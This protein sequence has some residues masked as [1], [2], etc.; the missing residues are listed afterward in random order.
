[1][2]K[3]K[4]ILY[5]CLFLG[6]P[7]FSLGQTA[8]LEQ[9]L[10]K[11]QKQAADQPFEK[12]YLHTDKPYYASGDTI[13]FKGYILAG[14]QH[15][16]S[17][18]SN[19]LHVDLIN[20]NNTIIKGLKLPLTLGFTSG[21]IALPDT[22]T[23]GS[24]RL[25][26]Y[27]TWMRNN[28]NDYFFDKTF[29]IV[30]ART[31][32]VFTKTTYNYSVEQGKQNV[33]VTIVY[34]NIDQKPYA[35]REVKYEVD[36]AGQRVASGKG[37]T[38]GKGEMKFA[39]NNPDAATVN[40]GMLTT[41]I[42]L[43]QS[44]KVEKKIPIKAAS[45]DVDV[46]FF[47]EGGNL[48]AGLQSK[49]AFK[50][51]GADGLGID[52]GGTLL[53]NNNVEVTKFASTHLG[54]GTFLF[55]PKAGTTYKAK[56]IIAGSE[57]TY[58]LPKILDRGYVMEINNSNPQNL[59]IQV[60]G[61]E[62]TTN[63]LSLIAQ[64]G[65]D[66][67][68]EARNKPGAS[69]ITAIIPKDKLPTGVVQFTL[70]TQAGEP[71]IER[72]VFI[73]N[74]DQLK[75]TIGTDKAAYGIREKV[76]LKLNAK[77]KA[78]QPVKGNFS[79]AVINQS[80]APVNESAET[81]ILSSVLLTSDLKGY[82]EQPN[83]YFTNADAKKAQE[84]DVLMLTQGYHRFAWR[85]FLAPS[86]SNEITY[87]PERDIAISGIVK[88]HGKPIP[89]ARV[90]ITNFQ[91]GAFV[92]DTLTDKNGRFVFEIG[93]ADS[94]LFTIR[95]V[96]KGDDNLIIQMDTPPLVRS[97]NRNESDVA[98]NLSDG[99]ENFLQNSKKQF[100][101]DPFSSGH[102]V[103]L[104]QIEVKDTRTARQ[105]EVDKAVKY[106]NNYNGKGVANQVITGEEIGKLGGSTIFTRLNGIIAGVYVKPDGNG[107]DGFYST[108]VASKIEER[109]ELDD[110]GNLTTTQVPAPPMQVVIDGFFGR[111]IS[112]V[113]IESISS[114]EVLRSGQLL[115]AYGSRAGSGMLLVTTK[116]GDQ[117]TGYPL[118]FP[119]V[120]SGYAP[121]GYYKAKQFY[122][123]K[124][125][126]SQ[127]EKRKNDYR[128]TISWTP[129]ID[130]DVNGSATLE[131]FNADS[132][133]TY[134]VVV[135][136]VDY[137]G[138]Q[139]GRQVFTYLVK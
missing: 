14:Q 58:M 24:Y 45:A 32:K 119:G 46:Q 25:R 123:P 98:V 79:A 29:N 105:K 136:G 12:A 92:L 36:L 19:V 66:V 106:S 18:I 94:T 87:Q 138:G 7:L 26:A 97:Q 83:Y 115:T 125:D 82:I 139:L 108:R 30:N 121:K 13:W 59:F 17:L 109:V 137:K 35:N 44:E 134:R 47:P 69:G 127:A 101:E 31:N 90:T 56:I 63:A 4:H 91:K 122:S 52:I 126:V 67:Y 135:E 57:S 72:L 9:A 43:G 11:L 103:M 5:L 114:I 81:T 55:T 78:G 20:A 41:E 128:S 77:D 118:E 100:D 76:Q 86:A 61:S 89:N 73:Q 15:H 75:L 48:V 60:K 37:V 10:S 112:T 50:A 53:D 110:K 124:Y 3:Y 102:S 70:F 113:P 23:E 42:A 130:T 38:D 133:G 40:D 120:I 85:S 116:R 84:L 74:N 1:M 28:S 111:D 51:V 132:P 99:L 104:Q 117:E 64:G 6:S 88:R 95:A 8:T 80:V 33:K 107:N 49:V 2:Y 65:G 54:M 34:T 96:G 27:T 22:L 131:F 129:F 39:F 93:F 68:F 71:L 16:L 21:D 62:G